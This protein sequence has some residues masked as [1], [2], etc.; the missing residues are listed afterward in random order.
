MVS[1]HR[2]LLR[3]LEKK[4]VPFRIISFWQRLLHQ[5]KGKNAGFKRRKKE[6]RKKK[7]LKKNPCF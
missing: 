6:E 2:E 3:L 1:N 4:L 5:A 7:C